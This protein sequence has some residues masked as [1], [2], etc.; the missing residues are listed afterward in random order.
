M[1]GRLATHLL[2]GALLR[3][4]SVAGGFATLLARGDDES[5]GLV[6]LCREAG[7]I[8]SLR[9]LATDIDG[10]RLLRLA[11]PESPDEDEASAWIAK[12]CRSDTDL[13]VVDL[14]IAGAERFAAET[15]S[16]N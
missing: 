13:W 3:Q 12:R 9:E 15:I 11:G 8:V 6:I 1:S 2:A 10:R 7:R 14:D 4:A 5:G 16:P